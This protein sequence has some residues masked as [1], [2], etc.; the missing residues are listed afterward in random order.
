MAK[1]PEDHWSGY[2]AARARR[3]KAEIALIEKR[4]A[5]EVAEAEYE[6]A[7]RHENEMSKSWRDSLHPQEGE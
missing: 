6:A 1:R 2:Q 4:A 7:M 3:A 5:A